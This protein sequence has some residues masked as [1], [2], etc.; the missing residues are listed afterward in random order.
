MIEKNGK[1]KLK[2]IKGFDN[3]DER[4]Y[5]VIEIYDNDTVLCA[6]S[7]GEK[8]F[9]MKD[10]LIDPDKPDEIYSDITFERSN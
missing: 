6:S 2:K 9:F 4:Y 1:Y 5:T 7:D 3:N 10:F 8:Y